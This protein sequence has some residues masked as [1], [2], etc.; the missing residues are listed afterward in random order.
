MASPRF[1]VSTVCSILAGDHGETDFIFPGSDDELEMGDMEM[2]MDEGGMGI[3]DIEERDFLD[4]GGDSDMDAGESEDSDMDAGGSGSGESTEEDEGEERSSR[5]RRGGSATS[6]YGVRRRC[7]AASRGRGGRGGGG[8]KATRLTHND[9]EWASSG[10]PVD[11]APFTE[12]VGPTFTV[13][14]DPA[15][16]FLTLFTPELLEHVVAETNRFASLCS[17]ESQGMQT[18]A[19][20]TSTDEMKAFIGFVIMMGVVKLPDLYD[21]WSSSEVL[22]CFPVASRITRKRFLELRRYLHFVDNDALPVRGEEGYDRL[23]KVRPVIEALR[24]SF[25]AAYSPHRECAIDEAM[26]KYK[27][28]SSLKQYLPMKPIK[29]GFKVWV[30]ADSTNGYINDFDVYTGKG[31]SVTTNLGAKVVERLSRALV[32]GHYHLYFDNFFSSLSLFDSLLADRLYACGTFRKH[33]RGIPEEIKTVKPGKTSIPPTS[34]M[35]YKIECARIRKLYVHVILHMI[36][37]NYDIQYDIQTNID[38]QSN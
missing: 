29:R 3:D 12:V 22:H 5:R 18:T 13:Q 14:D 10:A 7:G 15:S 23:G 37:N 19:W 8:R 17:M 33:R 35:I 20:T 34:V 2:D 1:D 30:R 9:R 27:G 21:Y 4:R 25:L 26:V 36:Y 38:I 32:G 24:H 16:T 11:V 28:R 6:V 31:E